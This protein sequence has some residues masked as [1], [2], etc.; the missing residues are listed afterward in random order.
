MDATL[1]W[2]LT[3]FLICLVGGMWGWQKVQAARQRREDKLAEERAHAK[4][5]ARAKREA[6]RQ[7]AQSDPAIQS[8]AQALAQAQAQA[9]ARAAR[10]RAAN[11]ALAQASAQDAAARQAVAHQKAAEEA[12]RAAS[13]R[14]QAAAAATARQAQAPLNPP[15][16]TPVRAAATAPVQPAAAAAPKPPEQTTVM[17]ADDSKVVRIKTGRLLAQHQY[18]VA[19]ATD[20]LDAVQQMRSKVPDVVIV[21]VEMPGMDGFELTRHLRGNPRTADIPIIMIT[22]AD[23]VH[24]EDAKRCGVDVLMGKPYQEDALIAHIR[25][26]MSRVRMPSAAIA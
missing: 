10:A 14:A 11:Q 20:G 25:K 22:S 7:A 18:R 9:Q 1:L 4:A 12:A 13:A 19:L 5:E 17:I 8:V 26:A 3:G 2:L 15:A 16:S 21:D 23:D 24:R 6:V